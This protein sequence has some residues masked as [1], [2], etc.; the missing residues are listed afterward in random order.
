MFQGGLGHISLSF[1][2]GY[3]ISQDYLEA[4]STTSRL[5]LVA[6]K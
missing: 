2:S 5:V 3:G 6:W 1:L 4:L